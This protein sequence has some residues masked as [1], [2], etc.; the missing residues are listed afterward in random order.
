MRFSLNWR[1]LIVVAVL[2]GGGLAALHFV[3]RAQLRNLPAAYLRQADAARD[4]QEVEKERAF[5]ERY[6]LARP[7]DLDAKERLIRLHAKSAR[8]KQRQNAYLAIDDLLRRDPT[9][10]DL[11]R[12][13]I[14]YAIGLRAT[15]EADEHIAV[16]L[17]KFPTDGEAR[18][19][20]GF[21]RELERKFEAAAI[22]YQKAYTAKPDLL[23]AYTRRA[24]VLRERQSKPEEADKTI[25]AMI[26]KNPANP[27]AHLA[28][29]EYWR[30]GRDL[31]KARAAV[32]E[33]RK[34]APDDLNVILSTVQDLQRAALAARTD[35]KPTDAEARFAEARAELD[36][37][38]KLHPKA[39]EVYL[40][41]ARVEATARGP[42]EAVVALAA[43][44]ASLPNDPTLLAESAEYQI[45]AGDA[46][47]AT[48]T[49]DQL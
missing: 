28:A 23:A 6:L 12:F 38:A 41:K 9:R 13:A 11:R 21:C 7:D 24:F 49:L 26:E 18:L 22:E 47:A 33:A 27:T 3:H 35:R 40:S 17:E 45:A 5:L 16:L 14:D 48:A 1:F 8:G 4:A 2:L 36:R 32:A 34:L 30:Q 20:R 37:A 29:A 10:H 44:L 19:N 31:E 43:G 42:A 25:G 15:K 46:K 39:V